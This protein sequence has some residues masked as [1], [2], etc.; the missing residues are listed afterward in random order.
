MAYNTACIGWRGI[1]AIFKH[2]SGFGFF[3][4]SGIILA[5]ST[6]NTSVGQQIGENHTMTFD[7]TLIL[8][9]AATIVTGLLAGTSLDKAVVQLPAR[10]RMS[11]HGFANFSR[12]NDLGNGLFM[13]PA[14]GI[15]AALL[16]MIAALSAFL[17]ATSLAQAWPLYVAAL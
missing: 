10:R 16:T 6:T 2:F 15:L 3:L 1:V 14:M 11:I 5:R 13:Y 4:L 12:A 8:V 7:P 9:L 17:R